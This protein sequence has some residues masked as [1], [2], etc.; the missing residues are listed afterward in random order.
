MELDLSM[1][2]ISRQSK[3]Y[4][5]KRN[6]NF[7][8]QCS[9]EKA[10]IMWPKNNDPQSFE[11]GSRNNFAPAALLLAMNMRISNFKALNYFMCFRNDSVIGIEITDE[12]KSAIG[13]AI[14]IPVIPRK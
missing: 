1:P 4:F 14:S 13:C 8:I 7:R 9:K 12:R 3:S 5:Y 2:N 6:S 10:Q 11:L